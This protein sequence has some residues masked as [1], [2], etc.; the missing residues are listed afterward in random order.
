MQISDCEVRGTPGPGGTCQTLTSGPHSEPQAETCP[1]AACESAHVS[2]ESARRQ[3]LGSC[4]QQLTLRAVLAFSCFWDVE[5]WIYRPAKTLLPDVG[6]CS[7]LSI[8]FYL[9]IFRELLTLYGNDPGF[10]ARILT[11]CLK[12]VSVRQ[13]QNSEGEGRCLGLERLLDPIPI[14][15]F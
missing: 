15:T 6:L 2:R 1:S 11:N 12:S 7:S 8:Y 14:F 9:P 4:P 10:L 5:L 3:L 13:F